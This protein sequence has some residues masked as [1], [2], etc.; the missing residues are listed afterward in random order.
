MDGHALLGRE[1]E[2]ASLS[3]DDRWPRESEEVVG[4]PI[5]LL[6]LLR[7]VHIASGVAWVGFA[8]LFAGFITPTVR[9]LGPVEG[10]RFLN[11]LLDHR[12]FSV[13][14]SSVEGLAVLSGG[15]LYWNASAGFNYRWMVSPTGAAFGLGALAAVA[16][17]LVSVRVSGTL[18]RLYYLG[19]EI[20]SEV[21]R[22]H[23]G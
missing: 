23:L 18:G 17:L 15:V 10:S 12:W 6:I 13:Y 22:T 8:F 20:S 7:I 14:I 1:R 9:T 4:L 21:G 19:E 11:R 5:W 2:L 3:C 16:A